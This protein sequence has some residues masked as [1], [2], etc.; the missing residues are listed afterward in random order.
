MERKDWLKQL[1]I[2]DHVIFIND[3]EA[4]KMVIRVIDSDHICMVR[5]RLP[6]SDLAEGRVVWFENGKDDFGGRIEPLV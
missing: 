2:G 5:V 4:Q 3:K 1:K 6:K